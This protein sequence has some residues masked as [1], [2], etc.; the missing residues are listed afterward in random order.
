MTLIDFKKRFA[1]AGLFQFK[2]PD[3]PPI[4]VIQSKNI[5]QEIKIIYIC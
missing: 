1:S 4:K 5:W 3:L 2:N